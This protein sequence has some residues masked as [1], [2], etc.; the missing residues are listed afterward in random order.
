MLLRYFYDEKLAHASYLVGCQKT[1][2]AIVIDPGRHIEPYVIEAEKEGLRITAAAETHIHADFISGAKEIGRKVGGTIYLSDEGDDNWKYEYINEVKHRLLKDGSTFMIG[3]LLFEVMHTPGHTP[4]SISFLLTDKGSGADLPIGIFTGDFVFVGD[5]GRPDLLEKTVGVQGTAELGAR[6][7]YQSFNRFISLPDFIQVWPAH[8]AGSACGK[9]L[10]A[11]PAT[12]VGYEKRFNW[13]LQHKDE[14]RFVKELIDGQPEPPTYFAMMK[15]L[16]KKGASL[17]SN[18]SALKLGSQ[19][20]IKE[21]IGSGTVIDT[22]PSGEFAEAHMEGSINIPY[23]RSFTTW[24][25]WLLNYEK[26]LHIIGKEKELGEITKDLQ[27][28]GFDRIKSLTATDILDNQTE[29]LE[30]YKERSPAEVKEMLEVGG[31]HLIDVRS[32]QEWNKGHI[33][34]ARHLMLGIIGQHIDDIPRDKPVVVQCQ[35]G[36]RS[37]IAASILQANG[38]KDVINLTGG[39]MGW[40]KEELPVLA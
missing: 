21:G 39:Y 11:I 37:A 15:R 33:P 22:R 13:A 38:I 29:Q 2:E 36:A 5:V 27:S 40:V 34:G 12:T 23:N 19:S 18:K 28:I 31:V 1:G 20:G 35:S 3:N 7:L 16:N 8:G 25:G 6:Q 14:D 26:E 30:C 4:E 10:G 17:L 32:R 24:A 9:A